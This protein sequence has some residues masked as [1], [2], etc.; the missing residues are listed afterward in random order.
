MQDKLVNI[1][2][3]ED[4]PGDVC[5]FKRFIDD[6]FGAKSSFAHCARLDEALIFLCSHPCDIVLLDLSLPDSRGLQTFLTLREKYPALPVVILTGNNNEALASQAM[7]Q[8]AQDYLSKNDLN[9]RQ[10][11]RAIRYAIDR[12]QAEE[13]LVRAKEIA[14]A[15]TRAKSDFLAVMS[16]EIRTPMNGVMGMTNILLDTDL[17]AEQRSYAE[18][19]KMSADRLLTM[20]NDILDF[21]K[22]EAGKVSIE[23]I[24]FDLRTL[25]EEV[26]E[27]LDPKAEEKRIELILRYAP[28]T[29][30]KFLG[31]A[32][33]V[34]Q[35]LINLTGNAVKFTEHGHVLIDISADRELVHIAVHD[36]GMGISL[37]KQGKLFES[38][39]Q[40]DSST[41]RRFGG[42]GLGLAISRKLVDLMRGRIEVASEPG[43]G[44]RFSFSLPLP[45]CEEA[46]QDADL[47]PL[48]GKRV[49]LAEPYDVRRSVLREQLL[50]WGMKVE[51]AEDLQQTTAAIDDAHRGQRPFAIIVL[52]IADSEAVHYAITAD[53]RTPR[54]HLI[55][56]KTRRDSV[57]AVIGND[58]TWLVKPIR[59][60]RLLS[61]LVAAIERSRHATSSPSTSRT[62]AIGA[63]T[64]LRQAQFGYRIL[65]AEDNGTNQQVA[66]LML[67]K[68]GCKTDIAGNGMEA[69]E[70]WRQFAYDLIL[71]DCRMPDMD[72]YQATRAIRL[73]ESERGTHTPIIALTASA[74]QEDI[75][76][77]LA[78]GMDAH[79][80]KPIFSRELHAVVEKWG[81]A[82]HAQVDPIK[83]PAPASARQALVVDDDR[84]ARTASRML[85]EKQGFAVHEAAGGHEAIALLQQIGPA[86]NLILIDWH[87]QPM[88]GYSLIN[89]IRGRP[90][91]ADTKII[92][93]TSE[94]GA[95]HL[96]AAKSA[97]ANECLIKPISYEALWTALQHCMPAAAAVTPVCTNSQLLAEL[98]PEDWIELAEDFMRAMPVDLE[99]IAAAIRAQDCAQAAY[100]AHK[101][102]GSSAIMELAAVARLC[103]LL[104]ATAHD[105]DVAELLPIYNKLSLELVRAKKDLLARIAV[106]S[107]TR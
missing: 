104:E 95:A 60:S 87:M 103:S 61:E 49:L 88:N 93:V 106:L 74:R 52:A 39:S 14:E 62:S 42:T 6:S 86:L 68:L 28:G 77:C 38:F 8:G 21:S 43:R 75:D 56:C 102:A 27:L 69:V 34:R 72:G 59:L 65:L 55:H 31:D 25:S 4:N 91:M 11:V 3:V 54:P 18:T 105:G 15:A 71:M 35:V 46:G 10:L 53:T 41:M 40:V 26:V 13:E 12:K 107:P 82:G 2:M 84:V 29:P 98:G 20:M 45:R 101:L 58:S 80:S 33:R 1:L 67:N 51:V 17:T 79:M 30:R 19:I 57:P 85:L 100:A 97:G 47:K 36:T 32:G 73:L 94:R 96:Q 99:A 89:T 76:Q 70:L 78:S 23:P 44:S 9:A 7:Q 63:G 90:N 16:H 64:A 83:A 5:L 22:I 50:S 92:L 66:T 48:R 24:S 37:E 81:K